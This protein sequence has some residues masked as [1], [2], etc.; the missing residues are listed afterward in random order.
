MAI[1][2]RTEK[3]AVEVLTS[4]WGACRDAI[5]LL[6]ALEQLGVLHIERPPPP[7]ILIAQAKQWAR[8]AGVVECSPA[9]M[10]RAVKLITELGK[11]LEASIAKPSGIC[12]N[13][14]GS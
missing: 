9:E 3:E 5:G 7:E 6:R 13:Q 11:A 14:A 10:S 12:P 4:Y 1:V 2:T 8:P